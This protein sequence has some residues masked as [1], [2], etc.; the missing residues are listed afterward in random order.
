[1]K[2][3]AIFEV[4][5]TDQRQAE[6]KL[7]TQIYE[8]I[9]DELAAQSVIVEEPNEILTGLIKI[10][11]TLGNEQSARLGIYRGNNG[12]REYKE[13]LEKS[14]T[15]EI[16]AEV[17]VPIVYLPM[18]LIQQLELE[19]EVGWIQIVTYKTIKL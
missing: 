13:E 16:L 8:K 4:K 3:G 18:R 14:N 5:S 2:K 19:D 9:T 7:V 6:L 10:S 11:D 1:M 17:S 12:R 15:R